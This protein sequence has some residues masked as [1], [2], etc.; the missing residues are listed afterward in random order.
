[1]PESSWARDSFEATRTE[2][3]S[4]RFSAPVST[5]IPLAASGGAM[6]GGGHV[7]GD[8]LK[9]QAED[10]LNV[11]AAPDTSGTRVGGFPDGTLLQVT[12]PPEGGPAESKGWVHVSDGKT[13]GWVSAE[14]VR[15]AD[16]AAPPAQVQQAQQVAPVH[17]SVVPP[18]EGPLAIGHHLSPDLIVRDWP[19][20]E[21]EIRA[22]I[23][24]VANAGAHSAALIIR[25]DSPPE[26]LGWALDAA[27]N[28]GL[29]LELRVDFA[30]R[31]STPIHSN[32]DGSFSYNAQEGATF[33]KGLIRQLEQL[34]ARKLGA[35]G[36]IQL[37]NEP[38]DPKEHTNFLGRNFSEIPPGTDINAEY[39][40]LVAA[41]GTTPGEVARDMGLAVRDMYVDIGQQ[42]ADRFGRELTTKLATPA[43]GA[44]WA[45]YN[46]VGAQREFFLGVMGQ[47]ADGSWGRSAFEFAA[48]AGQHAYMD[49]NAMAIGA[50]PSSTQGY[51][52][53][54]RIASAAGRTDFGRPVFTEVGL[55]HGEAS[56]LDAFMTHVVDV[57]NRAHPDKPVASAA[58]WGS[59][60]NYAHEPLWHMPD[61]A[62]VKH[63]VDAH[64]AAHP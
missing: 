58:I 59:H 26:A 14:F 49:P 17:T 64:H 11:R 6:P 22:E 35:I 13:S 46:D 9:V 36:S 63:A 39:L 50:Y 2:R 38:L 10:G 32:P 8:T 45:A 43:M 52:E 33:A 31:Q 25:P 19:V 12:T 5:H 3:S 56:A 15:Q 57:W 18:R 54:V 16:A 24:R 60:P 53:A 44:G 21:A 30:H 61:P 29:V 48:Q 47:Q 42:L 51:E 1:M 7:P 23:D 41:A 62:S 27:A 20:S 40:Q 34:D 28:R 37:G 55:G 4:V